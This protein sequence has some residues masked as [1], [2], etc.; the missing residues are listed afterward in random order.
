MG[1]KNFLSID[2]VSSIEYSGRKKLQKKKTTEKVKYC[3]S[4]C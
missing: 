3:H 2:E 4:D 1:Y